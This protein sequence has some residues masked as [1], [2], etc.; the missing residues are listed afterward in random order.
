[1][2]GPYRGR[3]SGGLGKFHTGGDS[4]MKVWLEAASDGRV[5]E[6]TGP[7]QILSL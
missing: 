4:E 5:V 3:M 2:E 6:I 1:M 7:F